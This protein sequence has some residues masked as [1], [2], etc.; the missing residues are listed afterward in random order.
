[1][2]ITTSQAEALAPSGADGSKPEQPPRVRDMGGT[3]YHGGAL[4]MQRPECRDGL[5]G[6]CPWCQ[7]AD[8]QQA[9]REAACRR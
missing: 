1:M 7:L 5:C 4:R 3:Y 2:T 8:D 9:E 6:M